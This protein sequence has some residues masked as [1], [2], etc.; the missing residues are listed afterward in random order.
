MLSPFPMQIIQTPGQ[1]T[2]LF[3]YDHFV[4]IIYMDRKTHPQDL[5][6]TW[7]GDSIGRW[8]GNT[9]VVDTI[10]LNEKSWLDQIGHPH[11]AALHLIERIRR[12][13]HDTLQDDI[14]IDDPGAYTKTWTG[15]LTF[16]LRP[17]WHLAE[18]VC[19]DTMPASA[20]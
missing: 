15:Q 9:L 5:D 10:G 8:E 19:E 1:I 2:M 13:D 7:M 16:K 17:T 20:K 4:R 12:V 6:P 18:Y 14:T 3:E 11:T